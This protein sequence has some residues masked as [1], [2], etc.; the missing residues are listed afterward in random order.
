LIC[1]A[2]FDRSVVLNKREGWGIDPASK[3]TRSFQSGAC[4][5]DLVIQ[6]VEVLIR[7]RAEAADRNQKKRRDHEENSNLFRRN[8]E[9]ACR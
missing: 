6:L 2:D 9:Q 8:L 7:I 4:T 3:L 1:S 5:G